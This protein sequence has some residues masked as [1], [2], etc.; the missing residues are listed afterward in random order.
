MEDIRHILREY[1]PRSQ[2]ANITCFR[3]LVM[4]G[5]QIKSK[6][7]SEIMD[8]YFPEWKAI[9]SSKTK[10]I[11]PSGVSMPVKLYY[12]KQEN[13]VEDFIEVD[14]NILPKEWQESD[15]IKMDTGEK[16]S[17]KEKL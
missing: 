16:K 4:Q 6:S 17:I 5:Y 14:N 10:R 13:I 2:E 1:K 7:F 12:E 15:Q 11:S 9:R 3:E 8:N